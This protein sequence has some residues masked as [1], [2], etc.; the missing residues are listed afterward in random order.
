[1]DCLISVD[2][3]SMEMLQRRARVYTV[4]ERFSLKL[5][6]KE[7]EKAEIQTSQKAI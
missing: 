3:R 7:D 4:L 6:G 2:W 5:C 1:M